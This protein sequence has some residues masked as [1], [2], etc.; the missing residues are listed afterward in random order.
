MM[1]MRSDHK[2]NLTPEP[3]ASVFFYDELGIDY[4]ALCNAVNNGL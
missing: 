4:H 3:R 2:K 1:Q